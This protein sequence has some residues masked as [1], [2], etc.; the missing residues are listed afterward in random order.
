MPNVQHDAPVRCSI[1]SVGKSSYRQKYNG[2]QNRCGGESR[3]EHGI[4][5]VVVRLKKSKARGTW[6]PI[7][8][9]RVRKPKA[10]A[11]GGQGRE[12]LQLPRFRSP[13]DPMER[14]HPLLR[15]E[16]GIRSVL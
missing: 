7:S 15:K 13:D 10:W 14:I 5:S 4:R 11:P 2:A 3:K 9:V 16:W 8:F 12:S 1:G 6:D